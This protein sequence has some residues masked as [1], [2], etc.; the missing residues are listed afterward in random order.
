MPKMTQMK[1]SHTDSTHFDFYSAH[2]FHELKN[3]SDSSS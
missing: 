2:E 3:K 1:T